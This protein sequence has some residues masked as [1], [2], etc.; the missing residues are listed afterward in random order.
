LSNGAFFTLTLTDRGSARR[1]TRELTEFRT[2]DRTARVV[3]GVE[4]VCEDNER[5]VRRVQAHPLDA[6]EAAYEAVFRAIEAG[7]PGDRRD[8][9]ERTHRAMLQLA[10]LAQLA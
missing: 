2:A 5:E 8:S 4:Y 7:A 10:E 3:D 6:L 9:V 1:G